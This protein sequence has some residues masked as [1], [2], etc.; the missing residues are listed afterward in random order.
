MSQELTDEDLLNEA[1]DCIYE[2]RGA[3]INSKSMD[4]ARHREELEELK[5]VTD[6]LKKRIDRI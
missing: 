3:Y 2:I 4:C 5:R 1:L 6:L